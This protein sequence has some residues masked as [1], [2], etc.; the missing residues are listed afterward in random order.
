MSL[1]S[2]LRRMDIECKEN[3]LHLNHLFPLTFEVEDGTVYID[4]KV[5]K[6]LIVDK[7]PYYYL[8]DQDYV[9]KNIKDFQKELEIAIT[10]KVRQW[11]YPTTIFTP[12]ELDSE[13]LKVI[14]K[15]VPLACVYI[16]VSS[17]MQ[18][19]NGH[20]LL[21]QKDRAKQYAK[22]RGLTIYCFYI[23]AG[24]SGSTVTKRPAINLM[25]KE[26][27]RGTTVICSS[28]SRISRNAK[29]CLVIAEEISKANCTLISLSENF[30][31]STAMGMF[32]FQILAM[33]AQL[34]RTQISEKIGSVLNG[35]SHRG[36]LRPRPYYGWRFNGKDKPWNKNQH[37][38][39]MILKIVE[40]V[41]TDRSL[42]PT[43]IANIL[44][45]EKYKYKLDFPDRLWHN[46]AIKRIMKNYGLI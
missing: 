14:P 37:E 41:A 44:N 46:E 13:R 25:L 45:A 39:S 42:T 20:S 9:N 31:T 35:L 40:L 1:V 21:N 28:I 19:E 7:L 2:V 32:L 5:S 18:V 8:I 24:I 11:N 43:R 22:Y 26:L 17:E 4:T 15:G 23:D 27:I 38:Q 3:V 36:K 12:E 16:R 10:S 6:D 33:F 30:D 29:D 34:E